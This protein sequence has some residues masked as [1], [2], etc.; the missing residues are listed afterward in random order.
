MAKPFEFQWRIPVPDPLLKGNTFDRWDEESN[1]VE[2][3]CHVQ[4]DEY[5]FFIYW[6]SDGKEGQVLE[7][8]QINDVRLGTVPK[9][10]EMKTMTELE[11]KGSGP[12]DGRT[13]TI[14]SG[15]DLVNINY[16]PMIARDA[17]TAKMWCEGLRKV[18]TNFKAKHVCPMTC[19]K[20]HWL[21]LC[22]MVN[23]SGKIPVRSI[24]RTF[25]SGRTEKMIMQCLKDLGLPGG[26][27]EEIER[28]AFTF[29]KFYD[30]YHKICPRTDIEELFKELSGDKAFLTI[31]QLIDFFNERQRDPRLNEILF[32]FYDRNRILQ[33]VTQY[34][35]SDEMKKKECLSLDGFCRYLMSDDNA[36]VFL[37]RLDMYQDM[38]QPLS[39]Y[40]IN[41]SHN[42][43]LTGRQFG[44]KSSVEMYRQVLLAGCRCVELDCWDG[45]NE[46]Q[47]PIITHGKA[48]CTDILFKDVINAIKE[49]AFIT[50]DLPVILSFENH[51]S[52]P[53]QYKMARYCEDILGDL[54]LKRKLDNFDL[55]PGIPL[56]SP[57]E[58]K[59]KILIKNKRLKSEVEK[60][61]L[62]MF[63]KGQ[64][65]AIN[66]DS[67][68]AEDANAV[69][70]V[71][72]EEGPIEN[73]G[74]QTETDAHPEYI[75]SKSSSTETVDDSEKKKG[76]SSS[77]KKDASIGSLNQNSPEVCSSISSPE[78]FDKGALTADEVAALMSNYQYTGA[79]TNIHPYLSAMVNYA[80]PVKFQ[81][82]EIAEERNIHYHMSSFNENAGLGYL[83]TQA[84][85]FVNYNKRQMS[86]IYPRGGRVDSSNYMPQIFW[87][88]GCQMVALNFQTPDLAMQLNQG[89][90][91][92]NGNCGYLLKPDF[93]RRPD[94]TFDPFS[95]SPVDGVIAGHCSVE[96][97]SGQF[98]SDKK[99]GT[100]VEVDMYGLPTDTIRKEF[101]TKVVPNNGL[102]P[103]YND[104]PFVFRK[105]V[106]PDLAVLRIAVYEDTGKL[107][108]QRILPLDGLQAGYRHISLRTEGNFPLSLPTVFCRIILKTYVPEGFED[109]VSAVSAPIQFQSMADK[110]E[111]LMLGMGIDEN[112]IGDVPVAKEKN[113]STQNENVKPT[114]QTPNGPS[115]DQV[116][117]IP[118]QS[119]QMTSSSQ[120]PPAK[121]EEELQFDKITRE[122]LMQ[123]KV[124]VRLIKK[125]Q[126]E[127]EIMKKK[128][129]KEKCVMSK[130]QCTSVEK[131]TALHEKE[132]A[133]MEKSWEKLKKKN[134]DTTLNSKED[135]LQAL[136]AAQKSKVNLL[137][138]EHT[139]EWSDM[140][141][142]QLKEEHELN[143]A[144][145]LQ[146]NTTN[147]RLVEEVQQTQLK[148]LELKQDRDNKELRTI[149]AKQSMESSKAV[150]NDKSI[151]NKAERDRR[152]RELNE[153]NTKKFIEERKRL[154]VK[155]SRQVEAIKKVHSQQAEELQKENEKAI[156]SVEM[157]HREAKLATKPET[158]V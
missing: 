75:F 74:G 111:Q 87:N 132:K 121:K 73:P 30:L 15:L 156:E 23:P 81:S 27:N 79:T 91:E 142:R 98:L 40:Y 84:I 13:V 24:T 119:K 19:L 97:I 134:D 124:Y 67:E 36:P 141:A 149:Q 147:N 38:D 107:I 154:A 64:E 158:V 155:H 56:P 18:T 145:I 48:M 63:L 131:M 93:M 116:K 77:G 37:D 7:C 120:P 14:C 72:G 140:I 29:D 133:A 112:D 146:Q 61:Q 39:H 80:Q 11:G 83:K 4:V 1:T 129:Q 33:I 157:M 125:Q 144:H 2:Y 101:R 118:K 136:I 9:I 135:K 143:K 130:Q 49:T 139:K 44:G 3:N 78:D 21:K 17:E 58:L 35:E 68:T 82:F 126:R 57:S 47:E 88:A 122:S 151:K 28:A 53:Q 105:V 95:E 20:K 137:V 5:G 46:D 152:I 106:L 94:R 76:L 26:K 31:N 138:S 62:E 103:I 92:Y 114:P 55:E 96:V 65:Q 43:Y 16:T 86:R 150:L 117:E 6:K 50:S 110:R 108:G 52:K 34:E 90:F 100:C 153:N 12:L 85:E 41:S 113:K 115:K 102:N 66:E 71:D 22:L 89:K 148:E 51:C 123:E 109:F 127:V 32:P 99:I 69:C 59:R 10:N 8:T 45:R 60:K 42:T 70:V 54:L 104:E 128:H 25:A